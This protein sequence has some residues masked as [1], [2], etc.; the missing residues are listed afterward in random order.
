MLAVEGK[1]IRDLLV[2]AL[3]QAG[4][5]SMLYGTGLEMVNKIMEYS[6]NIIF[7]EYTMESLN[8]IG[9]VRHLRRECKLKTPIVMLA[10]RLD[11]DA[12]AKA[13]AAGAN[14]T[15]AIPFSVQDILNVTK[16]MIEWGLDRS[17]RKLFFGPR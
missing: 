13:R 8:G 12:Q 10:S 15:V 6:P 1:L 5:T 16:K 11:D 2:T 14:E 3:K 4:A 9:F 17:P 7:C